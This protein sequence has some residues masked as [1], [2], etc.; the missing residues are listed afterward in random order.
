MLISNTDTKKQFFLGRKSVWRLRVEI[1]CRS[2]MREFCEK[3]PL[4]WSFYPHTPL[5]RVRNVKL[6][7]I[8]T[9]QWSQILVSLVADISSEPPRMQGVAGSIPTSE[10]EICAFLVLS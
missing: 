1:D 6:D 7:L 3:S 9:K 10:T 5:V 2:I 4:M 8:V